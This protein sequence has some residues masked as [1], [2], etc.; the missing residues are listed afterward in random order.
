MGVKLVTN[1]VDMLRHIYRVVL[2]IN[3]LQSAFRRWTRSFLLTVATSHT[4]A[5]TKTH[6]I[7]LIQTGEILRCCRF[8]L[9]S[10][11]RNVQLPKIISCSTVQSRLHNLTPNGWLL[12]FLLTL[13]LS[14]SVSCSSVLLFSMTVIYYYIAS[15]RTALL[16]NFVFESS[17]RF[18]FRSED[19]IFIICSRI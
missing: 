15:L 8:H 9:F 12:F 18:P 13:S 2:Y 3:M 5:H 4:D 7:R 14:L 6:E 11:T 1:S 17:S 16:H 19:F 10:P